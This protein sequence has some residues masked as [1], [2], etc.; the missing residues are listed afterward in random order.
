MKEPERFRSAT[1]P[2]LPLSSPVMTETHGLLRGWIASKWSKFFSPA[3]NCLP[4]SAMERN[5]MNDLA[6]TAPITSDTSFH[7]SQVWLE[8]Q[9]E[10][11]EA[12]VNGASLAHS[13]DVLISVALSQVKSVA[14]CAFYIVNAEGTEL[15]H[16]TGRPALKGRD[17]EGFKIEPDTLPFALAVGAS[18]PVIVADVERGSQWQ[19]GQR[20]AK[21]DGYRGCWFFP[22]R[23]AD[24]RLVGT[25]VLY[26]QEPRETTDGDKELADHLVRTASMIIGHHRRQQQI[27]NELKNAKRLQT[28]SLELIHDGR[29]DALYQTIL[30]G[31]AAI[32]RSR[33]ASLQMLHTDR[34]ESGELSVLAQKGFTDEAVEFWQGMRLD[35]AG[36]CR[37]A[38]RSG[39]RAVIPDVETAEIMRDSTDLAIYR[40]AGIRAVQTTPLYSRGG[41]V[42]GMLSTHWDKP[43]LPTEREFQLLDVVARQAADFME[44][45]KAEA[46]LRQSEERQAFLLMLSDTLTQLDDP[47]KMMKASSRLL[48]DH[49][50]ADRTVYEEI[51]AQ[52]GTLSSNVQAQHIRHGR[53][54]PSGVDHSAKSRGWVDDALGKGRA[55]VVADTST[56][57][58]LAEDVRKAWLLAGNKAIAVVPLLRNGREVVN[59]CVQHSQ[60]RAWTAA[61]VAMIAEVAERTWAAT[62]RARAESALKRSEDRFKRFAAASQSAIWIRNARTLDFEYA[63]PAVQ[64][65]YGLSPD[66][67][68]KDE[69]ALGACVVPEDRDAVSERAAGVAA[70]QSIVQEYRIQRSTDNEFRWIRSVGFP[71][72]DENGEVTHIGGIAEDVTEAKSAVQHREILLAELQHRVRNIMAVIRAV[73]GRTA[74]SALTVEEYREAMAGRLQAFSRVQ[75]LLTRSADQEIAIDSIVRSEVSARVNHQHQY[76][77]SGPNVHLSPKA[78][79]IITLALHELSINSLKFGALSTTKGRVEVSWR[80]TQNDAK[81][82]LHLEWS[83]RDGPPVSTAQVRRR[84]FGTELI[85]EKI[86]YELTGRGTL[87]FEPDGVRCLIEFPLKQGG[88]ILETGAP[89]LEEFVE[90]T[91][92]KNGGPIGANCACGRR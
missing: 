8:A 64:V 50:C 16:V 70:G 60:A 67:V 84:G 26:F 25:F 92:D 90:E 81:P 53:P 29:H 12:V 75:A 15:S 57:P 51:I 23:T 54:L 27:N 30:D 48:G 1:V 34:G 11:F 65:I 5:E 14:R 41:T 89:E 52:N 71:I 17:V 4:S 63:G 68:M 69:L 66:T 20:P 43:H 2:I 6:A 7:R 38:L 36:T 87:A 45:Q 39:G 44:R 55:V 21:D 28:I 85:E 73:N 37:Q 35:S 59:F 83:D 79:E 10:A 33:F 62:E 22:V 91:L 24:R 3:L 9:K 74:D 31:A 76:D 32:M 46:A 78:S 40:Q 19:P 58:R 18:E 47:L 86:P 42:I 82:W 80:L 61:E 13:L 77:L 56:D 88:S 72:F 49:I